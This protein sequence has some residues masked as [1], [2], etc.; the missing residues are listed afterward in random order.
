[1]RFSPQ[2]KTLPDSWR[3]LMRGKSGVDVASWQA[4]L[5]ALGYEISDEVGQFDDSTHN[6][7]LAFQRL[8]KLVIDGKVGDKTKGA[9]LWSPE[10]LRPPT[11]IAPSMR[12]LANC[13]HEI[14]FIQAKN[15][16]KVPGG[17]GRTEVKWIVLHS[18]EG[19]ESS[20]RAERSARWFAGLNPNFPAPRA[21]AH[22]GVDSDSIVGM[23]KERDVAWAAPGANRL[24]VHIEHA[25]RSRRTEAQWRDGFAEP[26]LMRSAWL[27]ARIALRWNMPVDFVGR[28]A[29]KLG[30]R[31]ITTHNEV[32]QAFN[33]ST[34]TDPGVN[35]PMV[36]YLE[37]VHE[38]RSLLSPGR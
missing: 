33:K 26:M 37:L 16:T 30:R 34:H 22:Y 28:D 36:W 25:G 2:P 11:G 1:M 4:T 6:A 23:V 31:G 13:L 15:Y 32:T 27:A 7:T 12:T 14:E 17:V 35:F 21:S 20:T 8:R 3:L 29:L 18:M 19:G 9:I 24:G 5:L 38:A 10:I